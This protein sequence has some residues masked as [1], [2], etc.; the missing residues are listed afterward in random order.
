MSGRGVGEGVREMDAIIVI[1]GT[2][3]EIT[4]LAVGLQGRQE[5]D[6]SNGKE[7]VELAPGASLVFDGR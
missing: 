2:A 7:L 4:A 6:G 5:S 3:K 1:G